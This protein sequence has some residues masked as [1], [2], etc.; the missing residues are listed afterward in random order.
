[1]TGCA[2]LIMAGI[3]AGMAQY[4]TFGKVEFLDKKM[5]KLIGKEAAI[6]V[7]SGGFSWVEGPAWHPASKSVLF[8]DIPKNTIYRWN[9]KEGISVFLNPSG[10]TGLGPYSDEPGANGLWVD[11][12]RT[13]LACE[14]GDRRVSSMSPGK[15]GK[16]TL[17]DNYEGKRLNS[18]NDLARHPVSG[19]LYFTDPPYGLEKKAD[20]PT[21]ELSV[22]GVYR[23]SREGVTRLVVS[24]LTRPNGVAFSPDGATMYVAVSDPE[25][26]FVMSYPVLQ[27]GDVGKGK[28][29]FDATPMV[30]QGLPGLPDGLKVDR[31]GNIWTTGPGGVLILSPEGTLLGRIETGRPTSNCAWGDDG[32]TLYI[33]AQHYLCRIRT[34]TKGAGWK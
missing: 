11:E 22:C 28:V 7:L 3:S 23:I 1:M 29:L 4:P 5:E 10:Y 27:G 13:L 30:K 25:K 32:S 9:E 15:G 6:E 34:L 14:H 2:A 26:A 33:T 19:E 18:P 8:A 20:D 16:R 31:D 17:S 24:D 21:R 12:D